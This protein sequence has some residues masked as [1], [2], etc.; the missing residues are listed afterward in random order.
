VTVTE[1]SGLVVVV[2]GITAMAG[3]LLVGSAGG[4]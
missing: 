2:D 4:T 3:A 1:P